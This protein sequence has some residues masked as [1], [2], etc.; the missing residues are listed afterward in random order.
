M[1]GKNKEKRMGVT[2][3]LPDIRGT[4]CEA[5][6]DEH[7][8]GGRKAESSGHLPREAGQPWAGQV[9]GFAGQLKAWRKIA[10]HRRGRRVTQDECATAVG[11]SARWWRNLER[12]DG[13]TRLDREQCRRLADLL[14]LDRDERAALLLYNNLATTAESGPVDPR[15]HSSLRLLVDQ[16]MPRPAYL[17]DPYWNILASNASMAEWW[18]WVLEPRANLMRWAL[19]DPEARTQYHAWEQH[20]AEYVKM[21]KFALARSDAAELLAL[22]G[23]VCED[24]DVRHIWETTTEL[25]KTRDGHLFR[26]SVPIMGQ[27]PI[28]VVSHVLHPAAL[29][30]CRMVVITWS[31][32]EEAE[33]EARELDTVPTGP[34][35]QAQ[36]QQAR[37]TGTAPNCACSKVELTA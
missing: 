11:R 15:V 4:G 21:L 18:P 29:P 16:Q 14:R 22:I 27:E 33:D 7:V 13:R 19:L 2:E 5:G 30:N 34:R 37:S 1:N 28:E 20:A 32:N 26:M 23:D 10:G 17:C 24:P 6:E 12:G 35:A 25:T 3:P 36:F 9:M 8:R 31:A